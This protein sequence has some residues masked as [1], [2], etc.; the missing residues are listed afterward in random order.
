MSISL[1]YCEEEGS[2]HIQ[3]SEGQ[4]CISPSINEVSIIYT[5]LSD[6]HHSSS[7]AELLVLVEDGKWKDGVS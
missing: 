2:W 4:T 5:F 3:S 6:I 1:D 7:K